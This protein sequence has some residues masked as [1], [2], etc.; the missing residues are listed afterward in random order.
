[1]LFGIHESWGSSLKVTVLLRYYLKLL[2]K[3][4]EWKQAL[5]TVKKIQDGCLKLFSCVSVD[6]GVYSVLLRHSRWRWLFSELKYHEYFIYAISEPYIFFSFVLWII[7]CVLIDVSLLT[8]EFPSFS[9]T[10]H[11]FLNGYKIVLLNPALS[12]LGMG[13]HK[14]TGITGPTPCNCWHDR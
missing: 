4:S 2:P 8:K 1:M 3:K 11:V 7:W 13:N 12:S 5:Y 14:T 10:D 6:S 9:V